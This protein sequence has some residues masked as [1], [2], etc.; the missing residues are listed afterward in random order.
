MKGVEHG[1]RISIFPGEFIRLIGPISL[2]QW[3]KRLGFHGVEPIIF[4]FIPVGS[5]Y[6]IKTCVLIQSKDGSD[7][8]CKIMECPTVLMGVL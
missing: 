6:H 4:R 1:Y 8:F 3:N 2:P 7:I 5:E